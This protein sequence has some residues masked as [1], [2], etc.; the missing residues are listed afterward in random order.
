MAEAK[1]AKKGGNPLTKK[2]GPLPVWGW[3]AVGGGLW[4]AL[5][6]I[7]S[8]R[9]ASSAA[10]GSALSG[11]TTIPAGQGQGNAG[12][13]PTFSS[14]GAWEQAAIAAMANGQ[15]NPAD[16]LNGLTDWLNGQCVTAAQYSGISSIIETVGLPPGYGT[17]IPA[18]SVCGSAT[19]GG[20]DQSTTSSTTTTTTPTGAT[21]VPAG[22]YALSGPQSVLDLLGMGGTAY[23]SG[24]E[25][26]QWYRSNG[27]PVPAGLD[28]NAY[29]ALSPQAATNLAQSGQTV[30][31]SAADANAWNILHPAG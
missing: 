10:A 27:Q 7:S 2:A 14:T 12:G 5:R 11:G 22:Y 31:Q 18:L 21:S 25:A 17:G 23:Q 24:A 30:Y 4:L 29:Y 20:T 3:A 15:L 28:P 9:A 16:A 6:F 1:P 19:S 26:A 13:L 8:R